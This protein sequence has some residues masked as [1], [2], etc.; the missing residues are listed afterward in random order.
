VVIDS[1]RRRQRLE[2]EHLLLEAAFA[3]VLPDIEAGIV[4][5]RGHTL[6]SGWSHE[7]TDVLVEIPEKYPSTPPDNVCARADLTLADGTMP[8]NN[9]GHREIAGRRWL[10]FSYHVEPS[11][12]HPDVD[13]ARSSTLVDYLH[14]ALSRFEEAT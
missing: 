1:D 6:P 9:Q 3:S 10:Q 7:E 14:G 2:Q 12:W 11:D 8:Q 4:I 13:L 5:V